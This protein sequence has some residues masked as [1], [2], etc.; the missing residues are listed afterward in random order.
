M[1]HTPSYLARLA[2]AGITPNGDSQHGP[3]NLAEH[4]AHQRKQER[5]SKWVA[6]QFRQE[7]REAIARKEAGL[8]S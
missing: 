5:R 1:N 2:M 3:S 7:R 4:S 8:A 6:I